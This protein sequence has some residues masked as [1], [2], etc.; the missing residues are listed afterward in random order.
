LISWASLMLSKAVITFFHSKV[1]FRL[2][3]VSH[4]KLVYLTDLI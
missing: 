2:R 3:F 1:A 4:Q